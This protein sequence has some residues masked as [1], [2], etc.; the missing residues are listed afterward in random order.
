MAITLAT[1]TARIEAANTAL[2]AGD[3]DAALDHI[4]VARAEFTIIADT[5]RGSAKI[6]YMRE[7][8]EAL[9]MSILKKQQRVQVASVGGVQRT[10]V[11]Y[12]RAT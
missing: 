7:G 5:E 8:L 11:K 2:L 3:Y 1:L 10:G 9:E 6:T 12:V 4:L